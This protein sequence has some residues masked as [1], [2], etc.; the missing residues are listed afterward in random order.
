MEFIIITGLSGSGKSSAANALEDIGYF[1]VDNMPPQLIPK[2]AEICR[3]NEAVQRVAMVTDIRGGSMFLRLL[4]SIEELKNS[5]FGVKLLFVDADHD[6]VKKRYKETRRK[7]PLYDIADGDIEKAIAAEYEILR[8]V[9]DKADFYLN[10]SL[11]S[12]AKLKENVLNLFLENVSDSMAISCLSFGYKYG[13]PNEADLVFDV[14][15]LPNPFY[16][17][18]LKEKTG[19]DGEVSGFVTDNGTAAAFKDKLWNLIDFLVP[20]YVGEG[21]SQLVIAFGCTGGRHRSV[22]FAELLCAYLK[23]KGYRVSALHRDISKIK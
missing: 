16:I 7:H 1:C 8:P 18:E 17:P 11:M 14:R 19:L 22:T 6:V 10:T 20:E 9:K 23:E 15:F 5:G 21:K 2:F 4:E 13:V 12:A 3:D